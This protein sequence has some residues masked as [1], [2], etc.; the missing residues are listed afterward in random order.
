MKNY[1]DLVTSAAPTAAARV[2]LRPVDALGVAVRDGGRPA[3][4]GLDRRRPRPRRVATVRIPRPP[5]AVGCNCGVFDAA[6]RRSILRL[7]QPLRRSDA[8]LDPGGG[9]AS[10]WSIPVGIVGDRWAWSYHQHIQA[11]RASTSEETYPWW[12]VIMTK[13][14]HCASDLPGKTLDKRQSLAFRRVLVTA[15]RALRGSVS[16]RQRLLSGRGVDGQACC[17]GRVGEPVAAGAGRGR[18]GP[19]G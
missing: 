7:G 11:R 13:R 16:S 4:C 6:A 10:T 19:G 2:R 3:R 9:V 14:S 1:T 12:L 17:L 8:G 15:H 18:I 5:R